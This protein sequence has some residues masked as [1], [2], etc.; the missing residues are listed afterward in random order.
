MNINQLLILT[1]I[2]FF[3]TIN[4]NRKNN[5]Y[6]NFDGEVTK[7]TCVERILNYGCLDPEKKEII[8]R[9]CSA[10]SLTIPTGIVNISCDD[11]LLFDTLI[12][13]KMISEGACECSF[14]RKQIAGICNVD[15]LNISCPPELVSKDLAV[16]EKIKQLNEISS[17]CTIPGTNPIDILNEI[18]PFIKYFVIGL[19]IIIVSVIY[20]KKLKK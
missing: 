3:Y 11:K 6:E 1:F 4:H 7:N 10:F 19:S 15:P 5:V 2:I 16:V 13:N 20:I 14:G 18:K 17:K 12:C 8:N 9:D